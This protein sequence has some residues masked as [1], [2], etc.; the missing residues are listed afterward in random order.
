MPV[1]F[2]ITAPLIREYVVGSSYLNYL[3]I[4]IYHA[5]IR[6]TGGIRCLCEAGAGSVKYLYY[7]ICGNVKRMR[8]VVY[9]YESKRCRGVIRC[10]NPLNY[11]VGM[12]KSYNVRIGIAII[13]VI[14]LVERISVFGTGCLN[15]CICT[16]VSRLFVQVGVL[17]AAIFVFTAV[18]DESVCGTACFSRVYYRPCVS[19]F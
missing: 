10:P 6:N 16:L 15:N 18:L 9:T 7:D 8:F 1:L 13:T 19:C 17:R 14:T 3:F 12:T 2:F 5:V 4:V 11:L